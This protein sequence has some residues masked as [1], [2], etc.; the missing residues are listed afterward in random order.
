MLYLASTIPLCANRSS[1]EKFWLVRNV[2]HSSS[3]TAYCLPPLHRRYE[4]LYHISGTTIDTRGTRSLHKVEKNIRGQS[5]WG[6][7]VKTKGDKTPTS[8][9]GRRNSKTGT[10]CLPELS[11][12]IS[13]GY[14]QYNLEKESSVVLRTQNLARYNEPKATTE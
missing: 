10:G 1:V 11:I 12:R 9:L 13:L 6:F 14:F 2:V 3:L 7:L 5:L 4:N 8:T